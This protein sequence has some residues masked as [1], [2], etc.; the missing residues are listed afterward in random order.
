M[1]MHLVLPGSVWVSTVCAWGRESSEWIWRPLQAPVRT[2]PW[3][4]CRPDKIQIFAFETLVW[5]MHVFIFAP[6]R[7]LTPK[8]SFSLQHVSASK[9]RLWPL[10]FAEVS[11]LALRLCLYLHA[12]WCWHSPSLSSG[13]DWPPFLKLH[14]AESKFDWFSK[15]VLHLVSWE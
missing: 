11:C 5:C 2:L 4:Q 14:L 13:H 1:P 12:V 9:V 3:L 8:F 10:G 7:F 6:E 15:Q